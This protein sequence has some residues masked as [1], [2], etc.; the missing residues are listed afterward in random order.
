MGDNP[1]TD[2]PYKSS[3]PSFVP[4]APTRPGGVTAIGV[5]SIVLGAMGLLG[6]CA[7]SVGLFINP[8][9]QG[10]LQPGP[11]ANSIEKAQADMNA[12]INAVSQRYIVPNVVLMVGVLVL[13]S[14][15]LWGGIQLLRTRPGAPTWLFYTFMALIVFELLRTVFYIF[16]QLQLLPVVEEFAQRIGRDAPGN[17][18]MGDTMVTVMRASMYVGIVIGV[19]WPLIKV[20]VY[21]LSMRYLAKPEIMAR[22]SEVA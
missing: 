14:A 20:I 17:P 13:G 2:N 15:L 18:A 22:G 4:P 12:Q 10:A 6:G 16:V 9:M 1:F 19:G 7:G 3:A 11:N 8:M 5:L 21:G